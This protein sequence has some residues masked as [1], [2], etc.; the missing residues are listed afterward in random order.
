MPTIGLNLRVTTDTNQGGRK[1][2]EDV[3]AVQ[4]EKGLNTEDIEFAYFAVFDGHGGPE[5][6]KFAK[7][8]LLD[9]IKKQRGFWTDDDVQ[10]MKAIRDAFISS[11][12][13]MWRNVGSWPRTASGMPSTAGSTASVVI[14]RDS[15]MYVAHVGD[16]SVVLGSRDSSIS[17]VNKLKADMITEDHKPDSPQERERIEASGGQVA[18][19][20]GVQRVVW[21][22]PKP[23]HKGPIRRSTQIDHIPFL[24]VARSLG[25]LW[26]YNSQRD[27]FVVSPEPDVA[28]Y[29]L[30]H[31]R[32]KVLVIASDGLW[33]VVKA[34]ECVDYVYD[35][36]MARKEMGEEEPQSHKPA[37][38]LVRLAL[39][40]WNYYNYR[41]DNTSV[42]VVHFDPPGS[43]RRGSDFKAIGDIPEEDEPLRLELE[44][45]CFSSPAQPDVNASPL[46]ECRVPDNGINCNDLDNKSKPIDCKKLWKPSPNRPIYK[47]TNGTRPFTPCSAPAKLG[48]MKR[49]PC[50]V[51]P[52]FA[53]MAQ[54]ALLAANASPTLKAPEKAVSPSPVTHK[55]EKSDS[56]P[57]CSEETN[58]D[59]KE[60]AASPPED[61]LSGCT[62]PEEKL[63]LGGSCS[64]V[65]LDA[66]EMLKRRPILSMTPGVMGVDI[67]CPRPAKSPCSPLKVNVAHNSEPLAAPYV[68]MVSPIWP[69]SLE[70]ALEAEAATDICLDSC[71]P[72][73]QHKGSGSEN[74]LSDSCN[75]CRI[76]H[77]RGM[78]RKAEAP[79]ELSPV[80]HLK[81]LSPKKGHGKIMTLRTRS[82]E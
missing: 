68:G 34:K 36:E 39:N 11:H 81:K 20:A 74:V 79:V 44:N 17:D 42:I 7:Q 58:L 21:H 40:R 72:L 63:G 18:A 35:L 24:A 54:H 25:D 16:S 29:R 3:L 73:C 22:R 28:M 70:L 65:P 15:K 49:I 51:R 8:C 64:P 52:K 43:S 57:P 41:A 75:A 23:H 2:M 69:D 61:R 37:S 82:K 76:L 9:E 67:G 13:L 78:K 50:K 33:N 1:Y 59:V 27:T 45:K 66:T 77:K 12:K 31:Q 71:M 4:F 80:K 19:K 14:I 26:S 6:A 46:T 47:G 30:N 60:V 56:P 62:P 10:V 55:D 53:K 48:G 38:A 5:A 32:H